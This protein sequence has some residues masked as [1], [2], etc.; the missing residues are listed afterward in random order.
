MCKMRLHDSQYGVLM[1]LRTVGRVFARVS[2]PVFQLFG[3]LKSGYLNVSI[4][5]M[6]VGLTDGVATLASVRGGS[7]S[8]S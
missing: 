3:D 2:C 6:D 1:F 4:S 5:S 7:S 8:I